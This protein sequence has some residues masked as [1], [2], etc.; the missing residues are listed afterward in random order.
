M[1]E[2]AY[3]L[4]HNTLQ[5]NYYS[6]RHT[7]RI[8]RTYVVHFDLSTDLS[9]S[10]FCVN[11]VAMYTSSF[12]FYYSMWYAGVLA[13]HVFIIIHTKKE[14]SRVRGLVIGTIGT[15]TGCPDGM[16]RDILSRNLVQAS[17]CPAR[18]NIPNYVN[19][20]VPQ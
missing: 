13:L 11:G 7:P 1:E 10:F 5:V 2:R 6:V 4:T 20:F 9:V 8:H 12:T 3:I 15:V 18:Q 16:Y 19:Y 14:I 17:L